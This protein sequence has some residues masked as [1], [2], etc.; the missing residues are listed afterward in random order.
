[1]NIQRYII[2]PLALM[3]MIAVT[4][5]AAPRNK[6]ILSLKESITDNDIVY[7]ESLETNTRLMMQ[8]W[9]LQNYT[10]LDSDVESRNPGT[11]S[12]AEYAKRLAAIPSGIELPYN[13]IVRNHIERYITRNR[14]L[15]E[16]M[17]G[18]S[19]YYMPIFEQALEREG[20]P[21]ELKY[22]PV[23]ES[24]LDPNAVSRAGAAGLWQ[25]MIGTGK[26][27]GLE[28]N[29]LVDE[30]RDPYR[31]SE[32]AATLL[33]NLYAI[34]NDWSLAIAAYNC[35]PGNVNKALRRVGG[36]DI[37]G[38]DFWD[39]YDYLPRETRG[40]VPA[41]I[42]ANYVMTY[43]KRHNISP[44]LARKPLIVDTVAVTRR[45]N[46]NQISHVLNMPIEELRVL[47]PQ[48]RADIVP[49]T[50]DR[51]YTIALPSQQIYSYIMSEDSILAYGSNSRETRM[52]YTDNSS[53]NSSE[54]KRI[55]VTELPADAEASFVDT[56]NAPERQLTEQE[57]YEQEK[58]QIEE[59][60]QLEKAAKEAPRRGAQK[61]DIPVETKKQAQPEPQRQAKPEKQ[62]QER[63]AHYTDRNGKKRS[64]EENY[65][66]T[67]SN[68]QRG[69]AKQRAKKNAKAEKTAA[70]PAA[71]SEHTIKKGESLSEIAEKNGVTVKELQ[72]ANN[73]KGD[74]IK[75]G[76]NLKIPGKKKAAKAK[77]ETKQTK[78][79]K[80]TKKRR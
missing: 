68:N 57:L 55:H 20:L 51:P 53:Y 35:G 11:V 32:K 48:Y 1:M 33:K 63:N 7:P 42:A 69:D 36:D 9:Y 70:K 49:A 59:V 38:L 80:K 39:V 62:W 45:V 18:M 37:E 67:R 71:T 4:A 41:F 75:A 25:F 10:V 64:Q 13:Q 26:G 17:L 61:V 50:P 54:P 34:Y 24:A 22:L 30:R 15:V 12:D 5:S 6:N 23:I 16:E 65:R 47:N 29:S 44:A 79:T 8:N 40:Y 72:K 43:F 74:K 58:R 60:R 56:E 73:L 77:T 21:L 46:F 78:Q 28:I 14:T 66:N 3:A 76:D 2:T 52:A 31:S 27:L 19:L